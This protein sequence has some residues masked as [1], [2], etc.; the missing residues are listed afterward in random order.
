MAV[1]PLR[2]AETLYI[3]DSLADGVDAPPT[4]NAVYDAIPTVPT[5][6][7][8]K[9]YVYDKILMAANDKTYEV[10]IDSNGALAVAEVSE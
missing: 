10:T 2:T 1:R 7:Q 9:A 8:I 6:A 5:E 4:T 3:S